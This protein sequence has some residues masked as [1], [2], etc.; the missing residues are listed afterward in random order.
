MLFGHTTDI[1]C[2]TV[3]ENKT[4]LATSASGSENT[5]IVWNLKTKN[6]IF[7]LSGYFS[8]ESVIWITFSL[9]NN[10]LMT[11][12]DGKPQG[13]ALWEWKSQS[14]TPFCSYKFKANKFQHHVVFHPN[15][16]SH[17]ASTSED[18]VYFFEKNENGLLSSAV[19]LK[20]LY[21]EKMCLKAGKFTQTAFSVMSSLA[22][23][24]TSKGKIVVWGLPLYKTK[25]ESSTSL[26]TVNPEERICLRMVQVIT[27][28]S[29]ISF[30]TVIKENIVIGTQDSHICFYSE[31]FKLIWSIDVEDGPIMTLSFNFKPRFTFKEVVMRVLG[32]NVKKE[33]SF[34]KL[35][36]FM[37]STAYGL[38]VYVNS[39]TKEIQ[40]ILSGTA[41]TVKTVA[42]HPH[43][44][45]IY[46]GD[47]FGNLQKWNYKTKVMEKKILYKDSSIGVEYLTVDST[48]NYLV[49]AFTDNSIVVFDC[50]A[51]SSKPC[52]VY[53]QMRFKTSAI[54]FSPDPQYFIVVDDGSF[55]TRFQLHLLI[56]SA[57]DQIKDEGSSLSEEPLWCFKG[58][59]R[60]H[61]GYIV[62][63]L[64]NVPNEGENIYFFTLGEDFL[65]VQYNISS[66]RSKDIEVVK[67]IKLDKASAPIC[68]CWY[69]L[70]NLRDLLGVTSS[71]GK[72]RV[73][74]ID[75][76]NLVRFVS[77]PSFGEP[78]KK[79][80]YLSYL[81]DDIGSD[82][83]CLMF[84]SAHLIG[85]TKFP[86]DGNPYS[87]LAIP[88]H[89]K[90]I[91]TALTNYD[92]TFLFTAGVEDSWIFMYE[93]NFG[94]VLQS[95]KSGGQGIDAFLSVLPSIENQQDVKQKLIYGIYALELETKL[96]N[97]G[98]DQ[99]PVLKGEIPI[100]CLEYIMAVMGYFMT[101]KDL[102]LML[103]DLEFENSHLHEGKKTTLNC[104]D[105]VKLYLNYRP[106][107]P[108]NREKIKQ[109][110]KE[111]LSAEE[112]PEKLAR[113]SFLRILEFRGDQLPRKEL[114]TILK[115][116][117][118]T[119]DIDTLPMQLDE[120]NIQDKN[121]LDPENK[122]LNDQE[123]LERLIPDTITEKVFLQDVLC[124]DEP[125]EDLSKY[126]LKKGDYKL[127]QGKPKI[128]DFII[129]AQELNLFNETNK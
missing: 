106:E 119:G 95:Q 50:I 118:G 57:L 39:N 126:I 72:L 22:Y 43:L 51:L 114:L 78:Y 75:T 90:G 81:D 63:T 60:Q 9:N 89:V 83:E 3:S 37:A 87:S 33:K 10:I 108:L 111:V 47:G 127:T 85:L 94:A 18:N 35:N 16:S 26:L 93:I 11:L 80:L 29:S 7:C 48:G 73:Y 64:F 23:T 46:F 117:K 101:P 79:N 125:K 21:D 53:D 17:F 115:C 86:V 27:S 102:Q 56:P 31:T 20:A 100:N 49:G 13:L 107:E 40:T 77:L 24:G 110:F 116:L 41:S 65:V 104:L 67:F 103:N 88:S 61:R 19:D 25:T 66:L 105:I 4:Y 124:L 42:V 96:L 15:D 92:Q 62:D 98:A 84:Y 2:A 6:K 76:E 70:Y 32:K 69:P 36:D 12:S 99:D 54:K 113:S 52:F 28:R 34:E 5:I 59:T 74:D 45:Y 71:D 68:M 8:V 14:T 91:S 1:T 58:K 122:I 38:T 55:V 30:L 44:P 123:E 112:N 128:E 82:A 129:A 97:F 109:S 120:G 121:L